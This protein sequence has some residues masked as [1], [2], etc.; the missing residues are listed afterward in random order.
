MSGVRYIAAGGIVTDDRTKDD[1]KAVYYSFFDVCCDVGRHR[2]LLT[3]ALRLRYQVYCLENAYENAAA[4]PDGMERDQYDLR[5]LH[6]LLVHRHS[7][8]VAGTVRLIRPDPHQPLESLPIDALCA[9]AL[10]RDQTVLPRHGIAEVSRFAVSKQFRRRLEDAPTPSGVALNWSTT[11][12]TEKRRVPH[13]SLGLV[14]AMIFNSHRHAITHWVAEMEPA[15]LRMYA[16][17]GVHWNDLGP[18][19][20]FHGK[21]QPCYTQLDIM[22]RRARLERPD[23]WA[24]IT[25]NSGCATLKQATLK[26]LSDTD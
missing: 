1:L 11:V 17:L 24:L 5:S 6:S 26:R 2:D 16:K 23:V 3:E 15:L 7:N 19:I 12:Q 18:P 22:L 21:R 10:L 13:L 8:Q 4:F 14:Q 20:E 25:N 9:E